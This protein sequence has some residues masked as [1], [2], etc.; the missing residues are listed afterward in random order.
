MHGGQDK[1]ISDRDSKYSSQKMSSRRGIKRTRA[2]T[3]AA[4]AKALQM[5]APAITRAEVRRIAKTAAMSTHETK[6]LQASLTGDLSY[7][8]PKISLITSI[9]QGDTDNSRDGDTIHVTRIKGNVFIYAQ[10]ATNTMVRCLI[11]QWRGSSGAPSLNDII[12]PTGAAASGGTVL[13]TYRHDG[14][15]QFS[16]LWDS[17]P[18]ICMGTGATDGGRTRFVM[19]VNVNVGLAASRNKRMMANTQFVAGSSTVQWGSYYWVAFSDVTDAS[20]NEPGSS[21]ILECNWKD[22]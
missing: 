7:D 4:L 18:R 20:G 14:R 22:V 1:L 5:P 15:S 8:N 9:A 19:P 13:E 10:A 3:G 6:Y 2:A 16:V 21:A 12:G 17:G 11:I